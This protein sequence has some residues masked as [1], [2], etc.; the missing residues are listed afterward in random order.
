MK[1][2]KEK[3]L[4]EWSTPEIDVLSV[5]SETLGAVGPSFDIVDNSWGS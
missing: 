3:I 2:N 1:E 4:N 5:T